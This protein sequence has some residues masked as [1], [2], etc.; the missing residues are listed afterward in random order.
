MNKVKIVSFI[1]I[2]LLF[3]TCTLDSYAGER[4]AALDSG[5]FHGHA[6]IND[7][8]PKQNNELFTGEVEKTMPKSEV[9]TGRTKKL[10][11][12]QKFLWV[13][14]KKLLKPSAFSGIIRKKGVAA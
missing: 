12:N 2:C 3:G 5:Y 13:E 6:E 9:F 1:L 4:I 7:D 10:C 8:A 14:P 11:R